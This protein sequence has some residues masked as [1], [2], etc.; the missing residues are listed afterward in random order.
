MPEFEPDGSPPLQRIDAAFAQVQ[1]VSPD[2][3]TVEAARF[4][5]RVSRRLAVAKALQDSASVPYDS[6][7]EFWDAQ[8]AFVTGSCSNSSEIDFVDRTRVKRTA[9]RNRGETDIGS[10]VTDIIAFAYGLN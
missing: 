4:A 3:A 7:N 8:L 5:A 6:D 10:Q 2:Q 1:L 9:S